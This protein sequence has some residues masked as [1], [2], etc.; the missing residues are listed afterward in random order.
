MFVD[1]INTG[2]LCMLNSD[3][4]TFHQIVS[5]GCS[6]DLDTFKSS[7]KV[8]NSEESVIGGVV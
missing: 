5:D 3:A 8:Y 2:Q 6:R 4:V 7:G 1:G